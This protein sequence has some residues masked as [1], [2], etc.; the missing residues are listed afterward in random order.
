MQSSN[1]FVLFLL[2]ALFLTF[3]WGVS[4]KSIIDLPV[5]Q[6]TLLFLPR[7]SLTVHRKSYTPHA[8]ACTLPRMN[9]R[10]IAAAPTRLQMSKR[11]ITIIVSFH[12]MLHD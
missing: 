12:E 11:S 7:Y 5:A 3:S 1:F 10:N 4:A 2:L 8:S 6:V 9:A